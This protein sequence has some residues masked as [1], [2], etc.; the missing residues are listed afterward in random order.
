MTEERDFIIG[1]SIAQR[2]LLVVYVERSVRIRIISAPP[3]TRTERKL[4][5]Q[6]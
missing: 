1:Y 5:E 4:Y 6:H 3:V 2:L